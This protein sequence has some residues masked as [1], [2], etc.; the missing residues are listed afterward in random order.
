MA[1]VKKKIELDD[2]L[3]EK[4]KL[5]LGDGA[6]LTPIISELLWALVRQFEENKVSLP[7]LYNKAAKDARE[8]LEVSESTEV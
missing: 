8:I 4:I 1:T 5:Y 7:T 6:Y 3:V 2:L